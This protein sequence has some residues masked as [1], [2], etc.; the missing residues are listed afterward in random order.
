MSQLYL[1][2]FSMTDHEKPL[3]NKFKGPYQGLNADLATSQTD[4]GNLEISDRAKGPNGELSKVDF[5]EAKIIIAYRHSDSGVLEG[6][7]ETLIPVKALAWTELPGFEVVATTDEDGLKLKLWHQELVLPIDRV[8]R[9]RFGKTVV[10]LRNFGVIDNITWS[11]EKINFGPTTLHSEVIDEDVSL[12][13]PSGS[14]L[15]VKAGQD[16]SN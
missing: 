7:S 15:T 16:V 11:S 6:T 9:I 1:Q 12:A 5:E 2:I 10:Y 8:F 3:Q 13:P 14:T 4:G